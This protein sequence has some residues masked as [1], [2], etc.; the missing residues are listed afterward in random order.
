ME[1][2]LNNQTKTFQVSQNF[3]LQQ[4]LDMEL[5]QRQKGIAVA[6]NQCVIP[7]EEWSQQQIVDQDT[8]FIIEASQGG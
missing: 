5:P 1:I 8:I 6:L 3:T 7:R 2:T 4:L